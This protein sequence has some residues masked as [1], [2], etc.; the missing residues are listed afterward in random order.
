MPSQQD[1]EYTLSINKKER[2]GEVRKGEIIASERVELQ[3]LRVL[4]GMR[5]REG[6]GEI[7]SEESFFSCVSSAELK[8]WRSLSR[9]VAEKGGEK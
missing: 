5:G 9:K 8:R 7:A 6:R 2:R 4:C 1:V 3:E